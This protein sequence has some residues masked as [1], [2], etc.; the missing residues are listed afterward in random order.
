MRKELAIAT[1]FYKLKSFLQI[2]TTISSSTKIN[3]T[4]TLSLLRSSNQTATQTT[5]DVGASS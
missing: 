3:R 2:N 1:P 4:A 5:H